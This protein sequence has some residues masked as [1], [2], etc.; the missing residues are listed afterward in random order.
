MQTIYARS[1]TLGKTPTGFCPGCMHAITARLIAECI[2]ELGR[3]DDV[4]SV[5]PIGCACLQ[6]ANIDTQIIASAHGR[7][8]AVATGVK[9]VAPDHLVYAYQG[10]GDLA[11]IG[12]AETMHAANRGENITVIMINNNIYGMTGGQLSPTTIVGQKA[13]TTGPCGRDPDFV[14]YPMHMCEIINQLKAPKFIARVALDSPAHVI[15]AKAAIKK[16]FEIQLN[17][18]GYCF[19][20]VMA[21][22]PT[23]WGLSPVDTLK[24]MQEKTMQEFPIGTIRDVEGT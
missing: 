20:E 3:R 16:A 10:D 2:D 21:N 24:F 13:S 18:G 9:R 15:K 1:E 7:A 19:I 8:A 4:V 17:G 11:A 12:M 14:G 6:M 22:C 23:N 5:M